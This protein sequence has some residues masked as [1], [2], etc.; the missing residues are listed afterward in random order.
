M[1][2]S[3]IIPLVSILACS[4]ESELPSEITHWMLYGTITGADSVTVTLSGDSSDT[5]M[6]K[7]NGG[8]YEFIVAKG[9]MY[10]ITVTKIG[11]AFSPSNKTFENLAANQMQNFDGQRAS[12][13]LSGTITGTDNVTISLTGSSSA[14]QMVKN[15]GS[16][17]FNVAASGTYT[18]TPSKSGHV[19]T[20]PMK[21]FNNLEA[22]HIQ[23]FEAKPLYT[24]SGKVSGMDGVTVSLSGDESVKQIVSDGGSYSFSVKGGGSYTV[25]PSKSGYSFAPPSKSFTNISSNQIQNFVTDL[26]YTNCEI[27][28]HIT[29][30][31]IYLDKSV[32]TEDRGI[33]YTAKGNFKNGVFTAIWDTTFVQPNTNLTYVGTLTVTVDPVTRI[34]GKFSLN[35][36]ASLEDKRYDTVN[37]SFYTAEGGSG[38][39]LKPYTYGIR[40]E[41][42]G[43]DTGFY[44]STFTGREERSQ[45]PN[46]NN[47]I[48]GLA[49]TSRNALWIYF[50]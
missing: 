16:Y 40:G 43:T 50:W 35:Y 37:T 8:K 6:V 28:I 27:Y 9:G 30:K 25:T 1:F 7:K 22:N 48:I 2:L 13:T 19:F 12:Y 33:Q 17:S 18:V 32:Y 38:I 49:P 36:Y 23:N 11:Y 41:I 34:V 21:E 39:Q 42:N 29:T 15:D 44:L 10:T 20:P 47:Y 45:S 5:I 46:T 31:V 14:T 3:L 26:S 24:I 4:E